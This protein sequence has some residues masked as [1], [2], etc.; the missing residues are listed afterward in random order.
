MPSVGLIVLRV[1]RLSQWGI[2][3]LVKPERGRQLLDSRVLPPVNCKLP[4]VSALT[5][6]NCWPY[7]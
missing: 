1:S 7:R 5:E 3:I 6:E 2:T 4:F